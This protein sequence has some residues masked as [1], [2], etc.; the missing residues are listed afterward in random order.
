[1]Q[2]IHALGGDN[3]GHETAVLS[4]DEVRA[5]GFSHAP[6]PP[7]SSLARHF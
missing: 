5:E 3:A 4:D 1:M 7:R 6:L 2:N